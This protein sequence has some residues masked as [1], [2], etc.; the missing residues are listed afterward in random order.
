MD[1]V[2]RAE[3]RKPAQ[4]RG[5]GRGRGKGAG[6]GRSA[7]TRKREVQR[8]EPTDP[9]TPAPDQEPVQK[10]AP[11]KP[12]VADHV[13]TPA[14]K[15]KVATGTS[16]E[17]GAQGL[18]KRKKMEQPTGTGDSAAGGGQPEKPHEHHVHEVG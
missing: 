4:G 18:R 12:K 17:Q 16:A 8:P 6:K 7:Q 3:G 5:R 15:A 10:P 14:Q 9:E 13:Q 11:K 1:F 2:Q